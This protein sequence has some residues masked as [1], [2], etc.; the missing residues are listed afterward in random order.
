[1]QEWLSNVFFS[2]IS[3]NYLKISFFWM[4]CHHVQGLSE[5]MTNPENSSVQG[6]KWHMTEHM[7]E[8]FITIQMRH[9]LQISNIS[10]RFA[11]YIIDNKNRARAR[12]RWPLPWPC[13]WTVYLYIYLLVNQYFTV[14][15]RFQWTPLDSSGFLGIPVDWVHWSPVESTK[16]HWIPQ[17]STGVQWTQGDS[18]G[19][20]WT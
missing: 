4:N 11:S 1:M 5:C 9:L 17:E 18:R 15:H 2:K 12:L 7:V 14:P 20:Q 3:K 6:A 13:P 19:L 8:I 16:V 10:F